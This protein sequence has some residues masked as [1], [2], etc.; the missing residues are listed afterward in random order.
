[1]LF[2]QI[3]GRPSL[4]SRTPPSSSSAFFPLVLFFSLVPIVAPGFAS[5]EP[6]FCFS[7]VLIL[8]FDGCKVKITTP[9]SWGGKFV[10]MA[11][12]IFMLLLTWATLS[13]PYVFGD[14]FALV[15]FVVLVC[16]FTRAD[17]RVRKKFA[18]WFPRSIQ[19]WRRIAYG[20]SRSVQQ[21][22]RVSK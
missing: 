12:V 14:P 10:R 17:V 18:G 7:L 11:I 15:C 19:L 3:S 21:S 20:F 2:G 16:S 5:C 8:N 1:M 13:V 9:C 22:Y 6:G 4:L